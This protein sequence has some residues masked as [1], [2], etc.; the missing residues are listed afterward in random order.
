MK[1]RLISCLEGELTIQNFPIP[2][3]FF[4]TQQRGLEQLNN[5][6]SLLA[7][8]TITSVHSSWVSI[9]ERNLTYRY[10]LLFADS[11]VSTSDKRK[12][13]KIFE[14]RQQAC[15]QGGPGMCV[16]PPTQLLQA[17]WTKQPT[18]GGE[19][20][21]TMLWVPSLWQSVTP[22]PSR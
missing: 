13:N 5:A 14:P 17:F 15:S 3:H 20:D 16:R 22:P 9:N 2:E 18:I 6:F 19:N 8:N 12:L 21:M 1:E 10:A 11:S 7:G 4:E